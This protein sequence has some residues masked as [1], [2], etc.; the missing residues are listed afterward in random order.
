MANIG[1]MHRHWTL[2]G[3]I[4]AILLIPA[5]IW[6]ATLGSI[7]GRH[8][9][10]LPASLVRTAGGVTCGYVGGHW[11]AGAVLTTPRPPA[12]RRWF[13]SR[14]QQA[15]NFRAAAR[16]ARPLAHR[17]ALLGVA[18]TFQR[19]AVLGTRPGHGCSTLRSPT[20][21]PVSPVVPMPSGNA[22]GWQQVFADNFT[23]SVPVGSF[24]T[25]TSPWHVYADGTSDTRAK[26]Q[27]WPSK[28]VSESGGNLNVHVHTAGGIPMGAA[29]LPVIA[30]APGSEG[31][32][33]YG[34]YT[35][36]FKVDA[37]PGYKTAILLWPDS[38]NYLADGEIDFPEFNFTDRI[39]GHF[40]R[41]GA[42]S[43]GDFA[44]KNTGVLSASGWHI[45]TIS[46]LPNSL[47]YQL[48]GRTQLTVTGAAVPSTP[49]HLVIQTETQTDNT[50]LPPPNASGDLRIDWLVISKPG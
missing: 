37:V 25:A 34:R 48:D 29:L 28:V 39:W 12:G 49:M 22:P 20:N 21:P 19:L 8:K 40:H 7:A 18:S 16:G 44:A 45:A 36:R 50:T 47:T 15:A 30:G 4:L 3:G 24:P 10:A 31:G 41:R 1:R 9:V 43:G 5:A 14:I 13:I 11:V 17:R 26:G 32:Q 6:A 27:Y 42:S 33:T 2:A 35:F 23:G 38:E 46:W